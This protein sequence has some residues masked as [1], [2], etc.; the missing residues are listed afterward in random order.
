[1][2]KDTSQIE[3]VLRDCG[4]LGWTVQVLLN[5]QSLFRS[6]F[7]AWVDAIESAEDRYAALAQ[8]GWTPIPLDHD[9][10]G[11]FD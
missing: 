6:R 2:R 4:S 10:H 11:N 3:C 9:D 5:E 7:A 1:M 8:S